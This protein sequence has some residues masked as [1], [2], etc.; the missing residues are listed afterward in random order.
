MADLEPSNLAGSQN[1]EAC[2]HS[3]NPDP[4]GHL[5]NPPSIID[6]CFSRLSLFAPHALLELVAIGVKP[7]GPSQPQQLG[8]ESVVAVGSAV[9]LWNLFLGTV[10]IYR[11]KNTHLSV[12]MYRT[13]KML[14]RVVQWQAI[15]V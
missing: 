1:F 6:S 7:Q 4:T 10:G 15:F 5:C 14:G 3:P 12:N 8:S 2:E 13:S 9:N 11:R